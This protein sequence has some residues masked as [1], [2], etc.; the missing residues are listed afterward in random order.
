MTDAAKPD[1]V[2]SSAVTPS[3]T[4]STAP[5][6]ESGIAAAPSQPA[7]AP[8][9]AVGPADAVAPAAAQAAASVGKSRYALFAGGLGFAAGVGLIAGGIGIM[10]A[11]HLFASPTKAPAP[12]AGIA[13]ETRALKQ[14]LSKLEAQVASLKTSIETSNRQASTQR[15]QITARYEQSAKTQNETQTQLGR[16]SDAVERLEKRVAAIVASEATGAVAPKYAAAAAAP[17]PAPAEPLP[18]EKP[19]VA[20]DW[21]IRSVLRGRA[22]VSGPRGV[23]EAAPGLHLPGLGRVEAVTRENGRWVVITEK[24]I[25][26]AMRRPRYEPDFLPN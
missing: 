8:E 2:S 11:G 23:F 9:I 13:N 21:S 17:Q 10:G 22:L 6:S 20:Q 4:A 14:S 25:I 16:I 18:P 1:S 15:S 7:T 3:E 24:G 26:T 5:S 19:A 12:W